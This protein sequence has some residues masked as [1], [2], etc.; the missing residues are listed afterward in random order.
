RKATYRTLI[1]L[2]AATGMRVGEAIGLDR[3]DF[4]AICGALTI[5]NGKLIS[6]V[7]ITSEYDRRP[8]RLSWPHRSS[9]PVAER[10]CLVPIASGHEAALYECA[11]YVPAACSSCRCQPTFGGMPAE[12]ARSST[13][14]LRSAPSLTPIATTMIR[15]E[16]GDSVD[17][18][19]PVHTYWYLSA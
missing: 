18:S 9:S 19:R 13:T 5:R 7:A 3:D 12:T 10:P 4:D 8:C 2:L 11:E 6:R 1:G 17:L 15:R 16:I 14:A